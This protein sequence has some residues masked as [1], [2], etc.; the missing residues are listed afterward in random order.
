MKTRTALLTA[1][2]MVAFAANS[3]LTRQALGA[4]GIDP[5]SFTAIRV[6]SGAA[7][8]GAL[9]A[10]RSRRPA[11]APF[12]ARAA[13]ML[14]AYMALF[15]F[16]Y[17]SLGAGAGA[18]ILFAAVQLTM[19]AAAMREGERFCWRAWAGL[20]AAIAGLVYLVSP[21]LAA[22]DPWG[23]LMMTGAGIA[24]G[25]YSL[26][27][28]G[29]ADPLGATT[30]NF[31]LCVPAVLVLSLL[32]MA[33]VRISGPG[34]ALAMISGALTSAGGYVIWYA[35]LANLPASRAATV[36]LS[37]PVIA[38]LGA[39]VLLGEA[40]TWRLVIASV[41]TL[42]GVAMVLAQRTGRKR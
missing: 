6:M 30:V 18:L 4:G 23:A 10:L 29:A 15:S 22:P 32:F 5:A 31:A 9:A 27:G 35:A 12:D 26:L 28:R 24:W 42:S 1:A 37:V 39:V 38:A 3:L 14:F 17:V 7:G 25:L 34:I 13:A 36:Q 41:L 16:A 8:L 20:A 33:H 21:G 19:F 2:A 11:P 40:L